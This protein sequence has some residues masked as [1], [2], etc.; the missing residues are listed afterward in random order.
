MAALAG[1]GIAMIPAFL[2][3]D[4]IQKGALVTLL[5]GFEPKP[6]TLYAIYPPTRFL[7]AKVRVFI[8]FL[9]ERFQKLRP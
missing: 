2:V 1:L 5:D 4:E 6:I 7:A 3:R 8:D 9:A